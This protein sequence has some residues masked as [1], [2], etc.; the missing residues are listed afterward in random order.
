MRVLFQFTSMALLSTVVAGC[1]TH[2]WIPSSGPVRDS[3]VTRAVESPIELVAV[4]ELVARAANERIGRQSLFDALGSE[5]RPRYTIG[6]G[7]VLEVSIWE[8]PP[9]LLFGASNLDLRGTA[10]SSRAAAFPDQVVSSEG[11]ISVP[12]AGMVHAEGRTLQEIE[13]AVV[14]GLK[15]KANQP[16][17]LVRLVRNT[18]LNVTVVGEVA[19]SQRVP[20]SPRGERLLDALAAAGGVRQP[21]HKVS[22]QVTRNGRAVSLP[23][24]TVIQDPRQNIVLRG[25]DVVTVLHQPL[26]LTVLGAVAKNEELNFEAQGITLAQALGR[27]GGLI[28]QRADASGIFIFRFEEVETEQQKTSPL[29]RDGKVPV[30]Y[31]IDLKNPATFFIAQSFPMRNKDVLYVANAQAN[32]LQKFLTLVGSVIYPFDVI[33]RIRQ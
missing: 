19:A 23:L 30:I 7:D 9:A 8:A 11:T 29:A 33:N 3:V 13:A 15:G 20:L 17:A 24:E 5:E 4:T 12:F 18:S 14:A 32:E 26:S 22:V 21:V 31:T 1:A 10:P 2:P 28:D 6:R 27:I 25:G 16:Q